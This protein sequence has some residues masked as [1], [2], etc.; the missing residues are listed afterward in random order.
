MYFVNKKKVKQFS[1]ASTDTYSSFSVN[2]QN[3]FEKISFPGHF[4]Y[5]NID[6][7]TTCKLRELIFPAKW[8]QK[9]ELNICEKKRQIQ[10]IH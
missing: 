10:N 9:A 3:S 5:Q 1:A 4:P 6:S 7:G 8:I 2:L